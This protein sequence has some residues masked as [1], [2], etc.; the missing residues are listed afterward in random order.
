MRT[1]KFALILA[2][3]LLVLIGMNSHPVSAEEVTVISRGELVTINA[4]L[5]TNG[6]FGMPLINQV[7]YFFD[8]SYNELIAS[9]LTDEQG[10]ASINHRFDE[11]HPLGFTLLNITFVG[12]ESLSLAPSCQWLTVMIVSPTSINITLPKTDYA[13]NDYLEI[14]GILID[15]LENP[16]ENAE[17]SVFR[18]SEFITSGI[19]NDTGHIEIDIFIDSSRFDL[20]SHEIEIVYSGNQTVFYR[21]ATTSFQI[22]IDKLSTNLIVDSTSVSPVMLNQTWNA[23]LQLVTEDN[24]L[25]YNHVNF[26]LDGTFFMTIYT[27]IQGNA[28]VQIQLNQSF[29][30]G[31]HIITF[32][33]PGNN[34]YES[35]TKDMTIL[36]GSPIHLNVTPLNFAEIGKSVSLEVS[37]CDLYYRPLPFAYVLISDSLSNNNVTTT[38]SQISVIEVDYLVQGVIGTRTLYVRIINEELLT[39]NEAILEIDIYS[40]PSIEIIKSNIFGYAYPSQT[41]FLSVLVKDYRGNLS[42]R[43]L[44]YYIQSYS[45]NSSVITGINGMST[46]EVTCPQTEGNYLLSINFEGHLSEFE[47]PCNQLFAFTVSHRI[48]V[49]L[50]LENYEIIGPLNTIQ[51]TLRLQSLNGTYPKDVTVNFLW[52]SVESSKSSSSEGY[53]KLQLPIPSNSGIHSLVYEVVPTNG[54]LSHTGVIYIIITSTDAN[55]SEGIGFYGI[56]IGFT[57]SMCIFTLP[58]VRRRLLIK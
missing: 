26:L 16:I 45:H 32:E 18:D 43:T 10:I 22:A 39:N 19:T 25:S 9:A 21:G 55:A 4:T 31:E 40:R 46:I 42:D 50:L 53:I 1:V 54:I 30:I 7:V 6:T 5:L 3:G 29:Q 52:Q 57:G 20:G 51:A 48:P 17:I 47:L 12:N 13:P 27:D 58:F 56:L 44:V 33:Y 28:E 24:N 38:I 37:V 49:A 23:S 36:V 34:R 15:D 35:C 41:L 14:S 11:S 2:I 8:Q